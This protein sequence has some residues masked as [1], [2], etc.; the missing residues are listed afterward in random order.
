MKEF[1]DRDDL[2]KCTF[3]QFD[4]FEKLSSKVI[5]KKMYKGFYFK[6]Y[7]AKHQGWF[8]D[9]LY[10]V[11]KVRAFGKVCFVTIQNET[12]ILS[13]D[14]KYNLNVNGMKRAITLF[15]EDL[16]EYIRR[17]FPLFNKM[18]HSSDN[19]YKGLM[20]CSLANEPSG[21]FVSPAGDNECSLKEEGLYD[22]QCQLILDYILHVSCIERECER[23]KKSK[24]YAVLNK[25]YK[26]ALIQRRKEAKKNENK[27]LAVKMGILAWRVYRLANGI[28]DG[29]GD[30]GGDLNINP[31]AIDGLAGGLDGFDGN[32]NF[33]DF[34]ISPAD[35]QFVDTLNNSAV[36][37]D[38]QETVNK[39]FADLYN[40]TRDNAGQNV[41]QPVQQTVSQPVSF[42]GGGA[43][44]NDFMYQSLF[45]DMPGGDIGAGIDT[46]GSSSTMGGGSSVTSDY[47]AAPFQISKADQNMYD[48]CCRVQED[49]VSKY[50]EAVKAGDLSE[51]SKWEK[52]AID[53][54]YGK[55]ASNKFYT[56][57]V[58]DI[59]V[60]AGL[61]D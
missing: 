19:V 44:S 35:D 28:G 13:C 17:C 42:G 41:L 20:N 3:H 43:Y 61:K 1:L 27:M 58:S 59:R 24:L 22:E 57:Y 7:M 53:A 38:S 2:R 39:I 14:T 40:R 31:S 11:V 45:G 21:L 49:A 4:D 48:D 10:A 33:A 16:P 37:T 8:V 23:F 18:L 15:S 50:K 60:S 51:A 52:T 47:A 56:S 36:N 6:Y 54:E 25:Q 30:G 34:L 12:N 32:S 5:R 26:T 9:N 55:Q 46:S 29:G